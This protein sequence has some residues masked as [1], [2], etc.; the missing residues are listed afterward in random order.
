[1]IYSIIDA[2]GMGTSSGVHVRL[3]VSRGLKST[4]YQNPKVTV[5]K[6]TI[7]ILPEWK[8]AAPGRGCVDCMPTELQVACVIGTAA[9]CRC[10]MHAR[11]LMY[12][13]SYLSV[14][15]NRPLG[16]WHRAVPRC[17][18]QIPSDRQILHMMSTAWLLQRLQAA[19]RPQ[20][21]RHPA[22]HGAVIGPTRRA[23]LPTFSILSH[24]RSAF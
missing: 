8:E 24:A 14:T 7:V 10:I 12:Q 4:P 3:M 19:C 16:A 18:R 13:R 15:A 5:G 6:P 11:L 2:N 23:G 9:L 21:A 22:V 1:M 20:G 17:T